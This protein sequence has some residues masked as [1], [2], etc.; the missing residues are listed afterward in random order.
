MTVG[1]IAEV[2]KEA[3][4]V[5]SQGKGTP[6]FLHCHVKVNGIDKIIDFELDSG[7]D[8]CI[9]AKGEALRLG[10]KFRRFNVGKTIIGVGGVKVVCRDYCILPLEITQWMGIY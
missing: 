2:E 6:L 4:V 3:G 10:I 1:E 5:L 8:R 9:L 7:A